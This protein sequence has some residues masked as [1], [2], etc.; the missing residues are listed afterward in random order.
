MRV[1]RNVAAFGDDLGFSEPQAIEAFGAGQ[2]QRRDAD[3]TGRNCAAGN[4]K[5]IGAGQFGS[6]SPG[7]TSSAR[8]TFFDRLKFHELFELVLPAG[9]PGLP[10]VVLPIHSLLLRS[11]RSCLEHELCALLETRFVA[12]FD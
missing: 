10:D 12:N 9:Q 1:E 7:R 3:V 2:L 4:L 6:R 8:P 5:W 11:R